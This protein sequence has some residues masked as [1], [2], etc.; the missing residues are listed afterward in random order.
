M[1]FA[2]YNV[3]VLSLIQAIAPDR[4]LRRMNV[5]GVRGLGR[6]LARRLGVGALACDAESEKVGGAGVGA[7][8]RPPCRGNVLV[9]D[10][11]AAQSRQ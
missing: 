2:G 4:L 11:F 3:T 8:C 5:P 6:G 1:P 7:L 10:L 9:S